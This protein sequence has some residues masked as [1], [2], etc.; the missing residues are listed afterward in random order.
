MTQKTY[1]KISWD[2]PFKMQNVLIY[3]I[4]FLRIFLRILEVFH[5]PYILIVKKINTTNQYIEI[6]I[7]FSFSK[8]LFTNLYFFYNHKFCV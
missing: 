5:L 4:Y 7:G 8:N 1:L 2:Y 6:S 3:T